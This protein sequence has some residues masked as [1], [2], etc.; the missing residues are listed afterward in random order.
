MDFH[1]NSTFTRKAIGRLEPCARLFKWI[2]KLYKNAPAFSLQSAR[3][4]NFM[5]ENGEHFIVSRP[6]V[7]LALEKI[8]Y[9][10][11]WRILLGVAPETSLFIF[12]RIFP[13]RHFKFSDFI[14]NRLRR[15][16]NFPTNGSPHKAFGAL[17]LTKSPDI[18]AASA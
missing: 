2:C 11:V 18:P 17:S 10:N 13:C 1:Q 7:P 6:I 5:S 3:A 8:M 15:F 4:E 12:N 9:A 16:L 14:T